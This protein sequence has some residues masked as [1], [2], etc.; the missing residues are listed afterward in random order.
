MNLD[1][2]HYLH[3]DVG[4]GGGNIKSLQKGE[5]SITASSSSTNITINAVDTS[6][7]IVLIS[8][9]GAES[10]MER[11]LVKAEITTS[12]NI[13]LS[14]FSSASTNPIDIS[15]VVVEFDNVKSLQKGN[16]TMSASPSS[17]SIS[18]V[19]TQKTLIFV[20]YNSNSTS[21]FANRSFLKHYLSTS[22]SISLVNEGAITHH[23]HWQAI[24]FN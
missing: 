5:T 3:G 4:G 8:F 21:T 9:F 17:I 18:A 11:A 12:T 23:I 2:L 22:T 20:S 7:A 15:W 19:D 6:K 14:R 1:A 24:E 10:V 16:F 13:N